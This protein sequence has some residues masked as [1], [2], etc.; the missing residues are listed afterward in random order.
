M[1]VDENASRSRRGTAPDAP[2][3]PKGAG[4]GAGAKRAGDEGY[5]AGPRQRVPRFR[6]RAGA[7]FAA[8]RRRAARIA[9]P[10]RRVWRSDPTAA[11]RPQRAR[12]SPSHPRAPARSDEA[13]ASRS[14][15]AARAPFSVAAL[16][17]A[18]PLSRPRRLL[19]PSGSLL[20]ERW[21]T[22]AENRAAAAHS[23][24]RAR[25]RIGW[26][27][28]RRGTPEPVGRRASE[29][30]P[31]LPLRP[32]PFRRGSRTVGRGDAMAALE[33]SYQ[34]LPPSPV[35]LVASVGWDAE[36]NVTPGRLDVVGTWCARPVA[37]VPSLPPDLPP[38]PPPPRRA[39]R[40]SLPA[41]EGHRSARDPI[42]RAGLPH[43]CVRVGRVE[44][45][46]IGLAAPAAPRSRP[47]A[48][49]RRS[50]ALPSSRPVVSSRGVPSPETPIR[51]V[52]LAGLAE[53]NSQG[54]FVTSSRA[55][56]VQSRRRPKHRV[57]A[58][59]RTRRAQ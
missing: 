1:G 51:R 47:G 29:A 8:P 12:R 36:A 14:P 6:R 9:A 35:D 59:A 5:P 40:L 7:D 45:A 37:S 4:R 26:H 34:G 52:P 50:G 33:L 54:W 21:G 11:A 19:H 3:A 2:R 15:R 16:P 18:L 10:F 57:A 58:S 38:S 53:I 30:S 44:I 46:R 28:P 39:E 55:V 25:A 48:A 56:R 17:P 43:G 22:E 31:P 24:S 42:R 32:P 49:R 23:G 20:P 13:I 27:P 41:A